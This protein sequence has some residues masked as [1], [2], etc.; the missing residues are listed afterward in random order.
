[1][2]RSGSNE[3]ASVTLFYWKDFLIIKVF[4][5]IETTVSPF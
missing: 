5:I 2:K 1:M 3:I 4:H